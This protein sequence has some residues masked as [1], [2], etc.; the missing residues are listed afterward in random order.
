VL[1]KAKNDAN[2]LIGNDVQNQIIMYVSALME[3]KS[4]MGVLVAAPTAGSCGAFPGTVL[5]TAHYLEKDED[6]I[7]K[8]MLAGGMIG[9]YIAA[10]STFAAE[11]AGCQAE[12]GSGSAMA[13]AALVHLGGG[14]LDQALG[15]ASMALQ[16][17]SGMVCDP[18]ANRVEA[19]CLGKNVIAGV[20]A[21]ACANMALAR[22]QHL[23]PLDEV[24][25]AFDYAGRSI[26]RTLRCTALGG[27][28]VSKTA[29]T[30]EAQLKQGTWNS[31]NNPGPPC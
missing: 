25:N 27:L 3:V 1:F 14:S 28:S 10:G 29:K 20:N 15:A 19:P 6:E 7:V 26:D 5:A 2:A 16:N 8:A 23:I 24:V 13:A 4:A 9:I 12:C 11:S 22:Y 18:I 21:L 30:I 17:C 31:R